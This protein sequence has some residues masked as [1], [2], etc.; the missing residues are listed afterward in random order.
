[1]AF[2]QLRAEIA[3]LVQ[4]MDN[5]PE[6]IHELHAR[7][8]SKLNEIKA[9]GMPLPDDLVV[10]ERRLDGQERRASRQDQSSGT[11]PAE[12]SPRRAGR[13]KSAKRAKQPAK[14]AKAA[15]KARGSAASKSKRPAAKA[16][17]KGRGSAAKKSKRPARTAR[18]SR[19]SAAK[20]SRRTGRRRR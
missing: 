10:L 11:E 8:R 17:K 9:M 1:M 15:K 13:R 20:K 2:E 6:D 7:I 5:E 3:M 19:G 12:T 16:A 14:A 4:Q 18:K